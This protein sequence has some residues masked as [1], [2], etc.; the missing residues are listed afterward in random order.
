[1][2][3]TITNFK[4]VFGMEYRL[5]FCAVC[6]LLAGMLCAGQLKC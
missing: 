2:Y 6:L 4:E 1:M 5:T 3:T